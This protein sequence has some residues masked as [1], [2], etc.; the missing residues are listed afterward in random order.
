[1]NQMLELAEMDYKAAI[2]NTHMNVKEGYYN[3]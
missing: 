1:M 2:V 3:K